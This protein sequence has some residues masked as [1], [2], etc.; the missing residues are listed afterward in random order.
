MV[1]TGHSITA[2]RVTEVGKAISKVV[3]HHWSLQVNLR[4]FAWLSDVQEIAW[5]DE[6]WFPTETEILMA[7]AKDDLVRFQAV[8]L[9]MG[10]D[11]TGH[12]W[13]QRSDSAATACQL[14][15][16]KDRNKLGRVYGPPR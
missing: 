16:R 3:R 14:R 15:F 1:I 12:P 10:L 5:D 11:P 2:R 4:G 7:A 8:G 13:A 6:G 9:D